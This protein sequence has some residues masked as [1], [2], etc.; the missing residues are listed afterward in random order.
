M[1]SSFIYSS[2]RQKNAVLA[3]LLAKG[4]S[5]EVKDEM[6]WTALF[7][8]VRAKNSRGIHI[9]VCYNAKLDIKDY[10]GFT[11]LDHAKQKDGLLYL[12]LNGLIERRCSENIHHLVPVK[13]STSCI[14]S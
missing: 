7:W 8:A 3:L 2:I 5:T 1:V 12:M 10:Y 13:K 14:I 9:L 6:G 11:P 4:A